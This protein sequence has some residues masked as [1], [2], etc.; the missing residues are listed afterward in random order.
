MS[1]QTSIEGCEDCRTAE[2][3]SETLLIVS[4]VFVT[5]VGFLTVALPLAVL[6]VFVHHD[7]GFGVPLA[8]VAVSLQ[9]VAT[10]LSR[11]QV[12]QMTDRAGAKVTVIRGLAAC[13]LGGA[14]M[15]V[16]GLA[17]ATPL[18]S[19]AALLASRLALGV[20]E[21][22]VSTG[23]IAWAIG[24]TGSHRTARI[25]SWNG[26]ATYGALA[27]GAPLGVIVVRLGG[28]AAL[29]MV[30]LGLAF[31]G[32]GLAFVRP[33]VPVLRA[34][35]RLATGRVLRRVLPYGAVLALSTAGF[36][37]VTTFVTLF[38]DHRGWSGAALCLSAFGAA[39]ILVR[40][41]FADAIDRVGGLR[42]AQ[43]SLAVECVGLALLWSAG[44]PAL[45]ITGSALT[46]AGFA[47]VFPA[48]GVEAVGRV[49]PES[50]GTAIGL[51]SV[52]LDVSLGITGPAAGIAAALISFATPF[53]IGGTATAAG[54]ALTF[55]LG[56]ERR[57][58]RAG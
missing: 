34:E 27:L 25:I 51:Y 46:G 36:G 8:G 39:F 48:L 58:D 11:A 18:V 4:T 20:G 17:V 22:L 3:A 15:L 40:L 26:I 14:L 55:A 24:R 54:L 56:R 29:G 43:L 42:V 9:Y 47:L 57:G 10:V 30:V 45:A 21:G 33:S 38:F 31:V 52:F 28:F 5:F 23:A 44:M 32:L 49:P 53:L 12:G 37:T 35:A 6:P 13:A 41:V 2:G 7:L 16:A 19:L 1:G 50:R